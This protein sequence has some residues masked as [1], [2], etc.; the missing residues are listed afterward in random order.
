MKEAI[1]KEIVKIE[2]LKEEIKN[3]NNWRKATGDIIANEIELRTN[4]ITK[5]S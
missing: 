4:E 5:K 2:A 1:S 3:S